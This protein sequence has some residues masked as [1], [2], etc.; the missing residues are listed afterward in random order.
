MNDATRCDGQPPD[1]E[2]PVC[3][4][5]YA[6]DSV[7]SAHPVLQ[8]GATILL[9]LPLLTAFPK[10][11]T[12]P[13]SRV[14]SRSTI[15]RLTGSGQVSTICCPLKHIVDIVC[16]N[17]SIV[18]PRHTHKSFPT[19]QTSHSSAWV[20]KCWYGV[21]DVLVYFPP[22]SFR[23]E[24][25]LQIPCF[26]CSVF[27]DLDLLLQEIDIDSF[28]VF[29]HRSEPSSKARIVK[30]PASQEVS[31]RAHPYVSSI[32]RISKRLKYTSEVL[33]CSTGDTDPLVVHVLGGLVE[34]SQPLGDFLP[35]TK[36]SLRSGPYFKMDG[37]SAGSD[38]RLSAASLR[39]WAGSSAG[40]GQPVKR[41]ICFV[42]SHEAILRKVFADI[43]LRPNVRTMP[44]L[45]T[46]LN[47]SRVN[48]KRLC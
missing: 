30:D 26:F 40:F 48:G 5:P 15:P 12:G 18:L 6:I 28:F 21:D 38:S 20:G 44:K 22:W 45:A 7:P 31:G 3:D 11:S 46:C 10:S 35:Q 4:K 34:S 19:T 32:D 16:Y 17:Q 39:L 29:G 37:T 1:L 36:G 33:R 47:M 8:P 41:S 42:S 43:A 25:R 9:K 23:L 13:P 2:E 24:L 27:T 14:L